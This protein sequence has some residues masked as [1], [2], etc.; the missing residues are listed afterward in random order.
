[1]PQSLK[2]WAWERSLTENE[3]WAGG[4][5]VGGGGGALAADPHLKGWVSGGGW[6]GGGGGKLSS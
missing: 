1:M 4:G 6:A 5:G 3:G 2:I